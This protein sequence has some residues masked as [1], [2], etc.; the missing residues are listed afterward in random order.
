MVRPDSAARVK[1]YSEESRLVYLNDITLDQSGRPVILVVTSA[2]HRPG[3]QGDP[4]TWEVLHY[5]EGAWRTHEVT[6]STHNYDTGPLQVEPDGT[7]RVVGPTERG[8]QRWGGGGEIAVW[9][10]RDQGATWAKTRDVTRD[11]PRNHSYVRRVIGAEPDSPFALLWA[12]G[13]ADDL[14]VS[15]L[16]FADREG[17]VVRRLPYDMD[18]DHAVPEI[19]GSGTQG[20]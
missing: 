1:A 10:S 4:R 7:W 8:P 17:R 9:T 19:L 6:T 12:D 3:P 18:G 16:Y 15:R 20:H 14:S 5:R 11:S 13:H 2:S